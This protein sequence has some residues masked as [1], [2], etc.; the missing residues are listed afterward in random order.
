M[1]WKRCSCV[2]RLHAAAERFDLAAKDAETPLIDGTLRQA[3]VALIRLVEVVPCVRLQKLAELI[4][5][6]QECCEGCL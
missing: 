3:G 5:A 6:L 2:Q 1:R 4:W